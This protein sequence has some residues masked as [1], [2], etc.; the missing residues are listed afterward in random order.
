MHGLQFGLGEYRVALPI[1]YDNFVPPTAMRSAVS[2][3]S[4]S[5]KIHSSHLLVQRR[6]KT[7]E[8][9]TPDLEPRDRAKE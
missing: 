7:C 5:G 8:L 2:L 6:E 4:N 3:K 1:M 9:D